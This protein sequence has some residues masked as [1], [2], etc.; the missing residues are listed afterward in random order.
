[1]PRM[2]GLLEGSSEVRLYPRTLV[3][4]L[5]FA[6]RWI[7]DKETLMDR[8]IS[9]EWATT[10]APEVHAGWRGREERACVRRAVRFW[11][12]RW[13]GVVRL[14]AIWGKLGAERF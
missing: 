11:P 2:E 8:P 6:G 14:R 9:E 10:Y 4:T 5:Y 13:A 1:M 7:M 3:G 12:V